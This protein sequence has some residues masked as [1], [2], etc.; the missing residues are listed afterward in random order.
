MARLP[1]MAKVGI[2]A[3]LSLIGIAA[4]IAGTTF[5]NSG[6]KDKYGD[7]GVDAAVGAAKEAVGAAEAAKAS[8]DYVAQQ[9]AGGAGR[10]KEV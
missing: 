2:G 7:F 4:G 9:M 8:A 10:F 3:G 5:A 1:W 6:L